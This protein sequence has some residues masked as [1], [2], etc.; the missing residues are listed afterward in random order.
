MAI[1]YDS[2]LSIPAVQTPKHKT[3]SQLKCAL[4]L[5]TPRAKVTL[6]LKRAQG[7]IESMAQFRWALN[8]LAAGSC[9]SR[10]TPTLSLTYSR[11]GMTGLPSKVPGA[12][13]PAGTACKACWEACL[14]ST[15]SSK[16]WATCRNAAPHHGFCHKAEAFNLVAGHHAEQKGK[17]GIP[18]SKMAAKAPCKT[19]SMDLRAPQSNNYQACC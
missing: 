7:L 3:N 5:F 15:L 9:M 1:L 4:R 8:C 6:Q 19:P 2:F 13:S 18:L 11:E 10:G 17:Q 14:A 16:A 12:L